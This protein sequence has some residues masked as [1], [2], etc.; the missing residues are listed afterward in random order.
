MPL[1]HLQPS[2][3]GANICWI[4]FPDNEITPLQKSL[5][6]SYRVIPTPPEQLFSSELSEPCSCICLEIAPDSHPQL[7]QHQLPVQQHPTRPIIVFSHS[8]QLA[9]AIWAIRNRVSD[10]FVQPWNTAEISGAINRVLGVTHRTPAPNPPAVFG[11][12]ARRRHTQ[13]AL[14]LALSNLAQPIAQTAAAQICRMSPA[15]FSRTF[16]LE[17]GCTYTE[18]Q[19]QKRIEHAKQLLKNPAISI[20][21]VSF[22]TG[23]N[24]LSYFA[25][26][27]RRFCGMTPTEWQAGSRG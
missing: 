14:D 19:L 6:G 8:P 15:H 11:R 13:P 17:N 23:F 4:S 16:R 20:K 10:Y 25:R 3:P 21:Q 1:Q 26:V 9:T 27:F 2:P 5:P 18:Y 22:A 24:D 7:Q 12:P